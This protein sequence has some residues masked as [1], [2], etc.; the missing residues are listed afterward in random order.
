MLCIAKVSFAEKVFSSQ[1]QKKAFIFML[2][3]MAPPSLPMSYA[4]V[5]PNLNY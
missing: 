2:P 1:Q 5:A 4:T 3:E